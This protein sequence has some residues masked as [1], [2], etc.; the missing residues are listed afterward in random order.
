MTALISIRLDADVQRTLEL[1]AKTRGIGPA[2]YLRQIASGAARQA[3]RAR[4]HAGS[5]A[6][7]CHVADDPE[8]RAFVEAWGTQQPDLN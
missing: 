7:A 4:V 6:V 1:E 3:R 8:A 5:A 2:T